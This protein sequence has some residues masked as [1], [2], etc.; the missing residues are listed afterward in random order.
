MLMHRTRGLT[1]R[2]TE[3]NGGEVVRLQ[4]GLRL[5]GASLHTT[6]EDLNAA[7]AATLGAS[8]L[9]FAID[10]GGI[11]RDYAL[12]VMQQLLWTIDEPVREL[13]GPELDLSA[14]KVHE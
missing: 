11:A 13:D 10:Q 5:F 14:R 12:S 1:A 7:E 8:L 4:Q 2:T 9:G 6:S 3:T